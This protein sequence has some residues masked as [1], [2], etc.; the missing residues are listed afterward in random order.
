MLHVP[1][2]LPTS[3]LLLALAGCATAAPQASHATSSQPA[4]DQSHSLHFAAPVGAPVGEMTRQL[5]LAYP[6]RSVPL[7]IAAVRDGSEGS[8]GVMVFDSQHGQVATLSLDGASSSAPVKYL[9]EQPSRL[10]LKLYNW[11]PTAVDVQIT[12]ADVQVTSDEINGACDPTA[13]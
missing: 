11:G 12:P 10:I 9:S 2:I 4:V 3:C 8:A 1:P 6:G 5:T 13:L 7:A